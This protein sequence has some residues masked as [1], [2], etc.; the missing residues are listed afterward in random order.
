MLQ[1]EMTLGFTG[2]AS[3]ST[4]TESFGDLPLLGRSTEV[5]EE[6]GICTTKH[7]HREGLHGRG[8]RL[9]PFVAIADLSFVL[10]FCTQLFLFLV[11]QLFCGIVL[12]FSESWWWVVCF[13]AWN[14]WYCLII[15]F[16]LQI[17]LLSEYGTTTIPG[18][19][20]RIMACKIC[21]HF[22]AYEQQIILKILVSVDN[23]L[24]FRMSVL[25]RI[26]YGLCGRHWSSMVLDVLCRCFWTLRIRLSRKRVILDSPLWRLV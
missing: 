1:Y 6:R 12:N 19:K 16:S 2:Y 9:S 10:G 23:Y 15:T 24:I 20:L 18:W 4:S 14:I 3:Q 26:L 17:T 25:S 8:T 13:V 11:N 5:S 21:E 7:G 22:D